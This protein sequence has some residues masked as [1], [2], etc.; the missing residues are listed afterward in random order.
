[1][2]FGLIR[3]VETCGKVGPFFRLLHRKMIILVVKCD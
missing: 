1:M 2:K 3:V